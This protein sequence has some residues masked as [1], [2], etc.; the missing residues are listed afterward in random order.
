MASL[1]DL[2]SAVSKSALPPIS[3]TVGI[4]VPGLPISQLAAARPLASLKVDFLPSAERN[5]PPDWPSAL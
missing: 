4:T 3:A 1:P 5:E 2:N